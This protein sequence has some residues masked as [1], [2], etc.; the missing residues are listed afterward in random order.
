MRRNRQRRM[1]RSNWQEATGTVADERLDARRPFA[2]A[3]PRSRAIGNVAAVVLL[4]V[5]ALAIGRLTADDSRTRLASPATT[6]TTAIAL[7]EPDPAYADAPWEAMLRLSSGG[8]LRYDPAGGHRIADVRSPYVNV[9]DGERRTRSTALT[10]ADPIEVW[11][12]GGSAAFGS[13]QRDEHTI[14]SELVRAAEEDGVALRVRNLA[15]PATSNWQEAMRFAYL[16]EWREPPDLVVFYDGFND[17]FG[18]LVLNVNGGGASDEVITAYQGEFD[19]ALLGEGTQIPAELAPL[20]ILPE[21]AEPPVEDPALLAD[22]IVR[23]YARGLDTIRTLADE[24]DLPVEVFW[25]PTLV[26]KPAPSDAEQAVLQA[27]GLAGVSLDLARQVYDLL[28]DRLPDL[29]VEDLGDVLD[30]VEEPVYL[31]VVHT[32]EDG[33]RIVAE[34]LYERLEPRLRALG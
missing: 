19:E 29:G 21:P 26:T 17:A 5:A 27:Q 4:L 28:D 9:S 13:G 25:Q 12:L 15:V 24:H 10:G 20:E 34:A 16:A 11:F 22:A 7:D 14:P 23:R 8:F 2:A 32:N 31:D 18:Q 3:S 33:A 1:E 6:T 30:G